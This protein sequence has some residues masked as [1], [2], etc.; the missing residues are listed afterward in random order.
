MGISARYR[1]VT[2]LGGRC[3]VSGTKESGGR[4]G[5][6]K[7]AFPLTQF[8]PSLIVRSAPGHVRPQKFGFPAGFP[9]T[10][11]PELC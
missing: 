11:L 8:V 5:R 4:R 7:H 6:P 3:W 2:K 9:V 1:R 10:S